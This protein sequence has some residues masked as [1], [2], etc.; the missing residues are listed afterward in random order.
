MSYW[1]FINITFPKAGKVHRCV[2]CK[3]PI[4]IGQEHSYTAGV[5]EGDFCSYRLCM[6][7]HR[8]AQAFCAEIADEGWSVGELRADLKYEGITDPLAWLEEVEAR[9]AVKA[10][11]EKDR[12]ARVEALGDKVICDRCGATLADY[13]DK[14]AAALNEA[15]PGFQAIERAGEVQ[16]A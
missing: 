13:A 2:E 10:Q 4:E 9:E 1:S 12:R 8:L 11:A 7:C 14:C 16:P 3:E 15:C 6:I 5:Q